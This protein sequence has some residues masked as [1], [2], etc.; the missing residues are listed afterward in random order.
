LQ[1]ILNSKTSIRSNFVNKQLSHLNVIGVRYL[2]D[3]HVPGPGV[4]LDKYYAAD[5]F[6]AAEVPVKVVEPELPADQ[7]TDNAVQNL[8]ILGGQIANKV[9]AARKDG[10]A[11]LMTGG[12]CCHITGVVGGLQ[13]VH[14]PEA[15][16]GLV[17]F[18]AHG[19]Y[20]TEKT[21]LS[22]MLGGMPVAVAAGLTHPEWRIG[23]HIIA[24]LPTD[25]IILVDV[26]NLDPAE[27]QLIRATDTVIATVANANAPAPGFPGEDLKTAVEALAHKVDLIYF[28]IDS[29]IL[30]ER[31][32]PNHGT[33]E[34]TGPDMDQVTAAIDTVMA[35][36]KVAA[37]A[38]V[39]VYG[40][41]EGAEVMIE[42]G[43]AL[44]RSGLE[45]WKKYGMA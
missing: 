1:A 40:E 35:T 17:W 9:A 14:G 29:D 37:Y 16:I 43:M 8:G 18:D 19:D 23:S 28:H 3:R 12:N 31:Y 27:E 15:R 42:S 34:P 25:R 5:L 39:S 45:S 11:I 4:P 36:G 32:T 7:R 24:P 26:R 21:S 20:N 10:A 44:I 13:D 2:T 41:G 38:V 30:D 6:S 22:G 33:K